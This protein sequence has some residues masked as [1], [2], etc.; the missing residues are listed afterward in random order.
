MTPDQFLQ[1]AHLFPGA[2]LLLTR[3]GTVLA[4]SRGVGDLGYSPDGLAGRALADLT[5]TPAEAVRDYL[6]LCSRSR[7]PV[8]GALDMVAGGRTVSCLCYGAAVHD[9]L[10]GEPGRVILRLAPRESAPS[11]FAVLNQKVE[12]LTE[13]VRRRRQAEER[14]REQG[15]WLR[16]TLAS[17]GDAVVT[18]DEAGRVSFLNPVAEGLTGWRLAEARGR[19]LEDI[20]RIVNEHTRQAVENPARRA[21]REGTVV[22]LANH[23]VLIARDGREIPIDDSG[24]PIRNEEGRV[25]GVVLIF[26]DV[27]DRKKAEDALRESEQ[28]FRQLAEHIT[29]VFWMA[30][31]F[32]P[33]ILYVSP[34]YERVWGRP[35]RSL[36]E[37]PRSFVEAVHPEDRSRVV[38]ALERQARGEPTAEEYRVVRPDGSVRWVWDR[39]FPVKD[40][41][42]RV[43]RVAGI[44]EDVTARRRAE[45]AVQQSEEKFR[46]LADTIPQLAW[47]AR[48]DGHIFWYNRRWYEYTGTTPEQMEGWG[49]QSVHDPGALPRV[50]DRWKASLASGEPFDMVFPLRGVD[51]VFRPF[52]TRVNPLRDD[53]GRVRYWFGTNTDISEQ[54]RAEDASRFLADASAALATVV[55]YQSTLEE[56]AALAVPRFGDWCGVDM[57]EP[58]GSLR[59]LAVAHVDPAKVRL[60]HELGRRYPPDPDAPAGAARVARTGEPELMEDISDALLEAAARDPEHLRILRELGL[61]SYLCVPMKARGRVLGVLSFVAAESGRRYGP[62]DL[63]LAEELARR[64]AVAV[65]NARL[66]AELREADRRKDEFLATLAHELRNPLAPIRNSLQILKMPVA[67]RAVIDRA[68]ELMERQ[69]HHLVRLV[70]DLLDVSRVMRG[71]VELRKERVGLAEVV[72]RAVETAQPTIDAQGHE[73]TIALPPDPLEVE[74]DAVRLAQVV[75]NLLT[76]AAKYTPRGGRIWLAAERDGGQAV[77]RVRDT[78]IGIAPDM[79]PRVFELFVQVENAVSRSQGGLGIGLTLARSLVEKH[80]GTI[81]VRSPGLGQGSEFTVRLPLAPGAA[82]GPGDRE[83]PDRPDPHRSVGRRVLVVDDNVDAAESLAMLLRL[84]GHDVWVVHDGPTALR[85]AREARPEVMFLDIGMPVMDGYEVARRVRA[86]P[87]TRDLTL[88]ALTGWGQEQ[89]RRRTREAGFD[90]HFV[91]PADLDR[92]QEVMRGLGGGR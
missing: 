58:D 82:A 12:E 79:L 61:R 8:V 20:F 10:P 19:P 36:Y 91:K 51:G 42:G 2:A 56:V 78:G 3:E 83:G 41:A 46:L 86:D 89:D 23:T 6:R 65:E 75:G 34:A 48:P 55:D 72:A 17:I 73:L 32:K 9:G 37:H 59:Q 53:A 4:A 7:E 14:L 69:L 28:R 5:A 25:A 43:V 13:E 24:A 76:N 71:K 87:A 63:A 39:A 16:V 18:T 64:A 67:D 33:D 50:L 26:R 90:H 80:G 35:C 30:D 62:A 40:A 27:T 81:E 70:D 45:E 49:W 52:L 66:Y 31:P 88:V 57:V 77:L 38:A 54:K 15:E 11:R 74:A 44:A 22:G 29:A 1:V 21:M 84:Q 68:R 60:A 47:M 92:I 85:A